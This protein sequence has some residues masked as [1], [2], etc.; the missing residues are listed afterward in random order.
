MTIELP[1]KLKTRMTS[2][3]RRLGISPDRFVCEAVAARLQNG[4]T[5]TAPS[6]YDLSRDLCGSLAGEPSDLARNRK[7][8]KGYGAWKW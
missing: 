7:H 3:A 6:L 5:T 4:S 2:M 8:L 1:P